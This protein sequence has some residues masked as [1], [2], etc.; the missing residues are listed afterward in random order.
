MMSR[1]C[2]ARVGTFPLRM[3]DKGDMDLWI[4]AML[5]HEVGFV[6]RPLAR[7]SVRNESLGIINRETGRPWLDTV[8]MLEGILCFD[9]ARRYPQLRATAP[10]SAGPHRPQRLARQEGPGSRQARR[11]PGLRDLSAPGAW[12]PIPALR[13]D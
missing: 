13:R 8:W 9:E 3:H 10:P 2:L 5:D 4:R 1:E 6:D 12:R 7:L 11:R